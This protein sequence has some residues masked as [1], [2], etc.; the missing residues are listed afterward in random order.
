MIPLFYPTIKIIIFLQNY[1]AAGSEV[2]VLA[3]SPALDFNLELLGKEISN[4]KIT[5]IEGD[6][7]SKKTLESVKVESFDHIIALSYTDMEVQDSDAKTLICLL[8]LRN[9]SKQLNQEF[10]IVSEMLDIRNQELAEVAKADD[11]IVS[12]KLISLML[13]Q[14]SENVNLKK[15]YDILFEADGSEIY[16]R[17]ASNY[18][19]LNAP[20]NFYT[21]LES[22]QQKDEVAIGYRSFVDFRN[23]DNY[24]GVVLNP[25]KSE[26]VEFREGDM[27]IVLAED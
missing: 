4:Q 15:V 5:F 22:S 20:V 1:V 2:V 7:N 21:V 9:F 14:M 10:S 3:E 17:P 23:S 13:T 27:I 16:L 6:I 19:A 8:H 11:Y 26:M 24:Y 12:D 25:K 18:V